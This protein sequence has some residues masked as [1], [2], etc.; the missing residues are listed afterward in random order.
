MARRKAVRKKYEKVPRIQGV[1]VKPLTMYCDERGG[2]MELLRSDDAIFQKFGQV[3]VSITYPGVVKAWHY[4][5]K[6]TDYIVVI[7]GMSKMVLYDDRE[8]SPTKGLINEFFLGEHSHT[9]I[10]IP[11]GVI[12]GQKPYGRG[13]SYLINLPTE[14]FSREHTDEYRIDPFDNDIPYNWDLKQE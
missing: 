11:P 8:G 3:Y 6:Q 10:T 14:T 5:K 13:P 4:H 1:E 7:K 12:H 9:L 2:L